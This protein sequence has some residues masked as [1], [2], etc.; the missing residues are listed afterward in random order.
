MSDQLHAPVILPPGKE[1]LFSLN[2]VTILQNC[3]NRFDIQ[4]IHLQNFMHRYNR[5]L[6]YHITFETLNLQHSG[7]VS[8]MYGSV[9]K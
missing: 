8:E 9:F 2:Y 3:V 5:M 4:Q 7:A 1:P 6:L